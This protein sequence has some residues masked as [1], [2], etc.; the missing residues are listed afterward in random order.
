[1]KTMHRKRGCDGKAA[2]KLL[3]ASVAAVAVGTGVLASSRIR[4]LCSLKKISPFEG[5]YNL[6]ES[7]VAYRY[8][9]DAIIK[10]GVGDDQAYIDAVCRQ[11]FPGA[12][13]KV[14]APKFACSA[15]RAETPDG[16]LM[17]R[18]YDFKDDTSALL[19]RTHPKGGYASLAFAALNN[20]GV[21]Q[22]ELS[23]KG[24]LSAMLAPFASLDG[25]NEKGVSIAVLTLDS[26]P[27]RQ[28]NGKPK[29]NTSLAIRLVLDR[30]ATT[31]EA[32]DL[33]G[34][35]DMVAMA[36]RDYHFFINDASGDS[37][38][39][40]YD[41]KNP[42]RPLIVTHAREVTNY[43]ACY[44]G[45]V[46]PNQRNGILGHGKERALAIAEVLDSAQLQT[47]EVAWW[48][49]RASSQAPN[50]EDITS[51]TQWSIVYDNTNCTAD[52][53]LRRTWSETFSFVV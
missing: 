48:A 44:A 17:G 4:T 21:N 43:Y 13:L 35:Y 37:R 51:N 52:F 23:L 7:N 41:P 10:A 27:T 39:V 42:A 40:E 2:G 8:D 3:A 14:Q 30:A 6:Y 5:P 33:L 49:L 22:P 20:L 50:P 19:V 26:D 45:E 31:Q 16:I 11:V 36:G 34:S 18:N 1:M 15:F 24:R 29:I 12:P 9:L 47:K 32:V 28:N 38:V 46:L 25:I 53:V